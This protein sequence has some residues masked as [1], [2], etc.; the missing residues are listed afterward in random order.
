M[1]TNSCM[2]KVQASASLSQHRLLA[3]RSQSPMYCLGMLYSALRFLETQ[4]NEA[5][6]SAASF[7]WVLCPDITGY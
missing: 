1:A 7:I 5:A 3:E 2:E 4:I 6:R